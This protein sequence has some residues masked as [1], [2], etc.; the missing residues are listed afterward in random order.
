MISRLS[1][2]CSDALASVAVLA[3]VLLVLVSV[4]VRV[5]EQLHTAIGATTPATLADLTAQVGDAGAVL[6]EAAWTQSVDHAPMMIFVVVASVL[7]L[8]LVRS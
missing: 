8:S 2:V 1:H 7:L 3:A 5:R 6:V 4:D